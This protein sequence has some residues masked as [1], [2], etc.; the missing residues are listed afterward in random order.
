LKSVL[1]AVA[2]IHLAV[3]ARQTQAPS[4]VGSRLLDEFGCGNDQQQAGARAVIL[5]VLDRPPRP[6]RVASSQ[7]ISNLILN[8]ATM[9]AARQLQFGQV[10]GAVSTTSTYDHNA[11]RKRML[12]SEDSRAMVEE[13]PALRRYGRTLCRNNATADD[14]VQDT[15][16]RAIAKIHLYQP[17]TNL[18]LWLF[19]IMRNIFFDNCRRSKNLATVSVEL[20]HMKADY[21]AADQLDKLAHQ[22]LIRELGT[23][24][25][26]Y[27]NLLTLIAI[28]GVSYEEAAELTGVPIGTIRSRLFRGRNALLNKV[29]G[30]QVARNSSRGRA[31]KR[32]D[33]DRPGF[34]EEDAPIQC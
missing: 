22:D 1:R 34:A 12:M 16:E 30:E 27:K 9:V 26:E 29:E 5:T 3:V 25:P 33:S 31:T 32:K 23:L 4:P 7:M 21:H 13:I 20:S 28:D 18:R 24:K 17:G 15:L 6:S 11:G 14:L 10:E 8:S 2:V 19:T